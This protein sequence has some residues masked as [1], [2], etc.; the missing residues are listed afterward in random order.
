MLKYTFIKKHGTYLIICISILLIVSLGFIEYNRYNTNTLVVEGF[1]D[2][3]DTDYLEPPKDI[4]S[5]DLWT[6]LTNKMNKTTPD[7]NFTAEKLKSSYTNFINK[8]EINYFLDNGK[9]PWSKYVTNRFKEMLPSTVNGETINKDD[10]VN[11]L[12]SN[13]PNR[14]AYKQ[15]ITSPDMKESLTSIQY[16]VYSGDKPAPTVKK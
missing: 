6:I 13:F 15:Y 10:Q 12:M 16:L 14:Y 3:K 1:D 8:E 9:F 11:K 7:L 2:I 4:I 5:D